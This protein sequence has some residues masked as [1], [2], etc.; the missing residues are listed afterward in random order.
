M[1]GLDEDEVAALYARLA[2]EP[3]ELTRERAVAVTLE[4]I[5]RRAPTAVIRFGEGEARVLA[6][7]PRD[8]MSIRVAANKLKRQMG[9]RH[10]RDDVLRIRSMLLRAFD[11]ADIVGLR[12]S[13]SFSDEHTM[14]VR[15][16]ESAFTERVAAGRSPAFVTHCLVNNVLRDNLSSLIAGRDLVS[17]VSCRNIGTALAQQHGIGDVASY[18]VPSQ[19]IMRAVDGDYEAQLHDVAFWPDFYFGLRRRLRVREPGEIF[20]VGA[21]I[22]GK[23]LCLRIRELGGIAL[24]M[25]SCLDGLAGKVT[26]GS[27]RPEP[28]RPVAPNPAERRVGRRS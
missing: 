10:S 21:G 25:G 22:L 12:G 23:E 2:R 5:S 28:Y 13:D 20:L 19:H 27:G 9:R 17:V 15:R 1:H 18:Q 8:A 16:T 4:R 3:V 7:E 6:A 14:W 26:R 11:G 24:D